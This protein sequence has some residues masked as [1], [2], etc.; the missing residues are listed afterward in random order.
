[1]V[2]AHTSKCPNSHL[3][4]SP[5][6]TQH[7]LLKL[8]TCSSAGIGLTAGKAKL[9]DSNSKLIHCISCEYFTW[10]KGKFKHVFIPEG[11]QLQ[12]NGTWSYSIWPTAMSEGIKSW[13]KIKLKKAFPAPEWLLFFSSLLTYAR[14]SLIP[15]TGSPQRRAFTFALNIFPQLQS[16]N[17]S[18]FFCTF[19][20]DLSANAQQPCRKL[21]YDPK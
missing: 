16:S 17:R 21:R 18:P 9:N 19:F 12:N 8:L 6:K 2:F 11:L 20:K 14:Y 7:L 13:I 3:Q 5:R 10:V 4:V 15:S 1:M